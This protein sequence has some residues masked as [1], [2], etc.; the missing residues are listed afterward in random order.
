MANNNLESKARGAIAS[1]LA[2]QGVMVALF[3]VAALFWP[4]LTAKVFISL[5]GL[6]VLIWGL[7]G[8]VH[9]FLNL[10]RTKFWWIE[11]IFSVLVI[12]LGIF[13]LRNPEV[14]GEII[15]LLVG[16]TLIIRGVV[17]MITGIFAKESA[18]R[19]NRVFY[20]LLGLLGAVAGIIVVSYPVASGIAFVWV[21][22][23]YLLLYGILDIA[24]A[25]AVRGSK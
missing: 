15:V 2:T 22:G 24:L 13:L 7:I 16:L 21:F 23:L 4:G 14:T 17:D 11:M 8:L 18:I 25:F 12:G 1:V 9:S 5:F 6:F 19:R 10:R 3:G 20:I